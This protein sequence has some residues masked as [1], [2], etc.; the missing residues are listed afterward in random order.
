MYISSILGD[1]LHVILHGIKFDINSSYIGF[2]LTKY[3]LLSLQASLQLR[4]E[5]GQ[6]FFS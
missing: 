4:G 3:G 6:F 2:N 5:E 1:F